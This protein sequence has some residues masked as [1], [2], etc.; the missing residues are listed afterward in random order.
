MEWNNMK[1][2]MLDTTSALVEKFTGK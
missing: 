2:C 1:K